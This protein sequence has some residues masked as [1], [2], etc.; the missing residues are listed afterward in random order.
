[1]EVIASIGIIFVENTELKRG[2]QA[3]RVCGSIT[4]N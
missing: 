1:M 2:S 3:Y 4:L